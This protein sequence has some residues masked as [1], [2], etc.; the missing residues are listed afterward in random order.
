MNSEKQNVVQ[1]EIG[2]EKLE[3]LFN[4]GELCAADFRC[5][6]CVSKKCV[7]N[8]CLTSCA[9]RMRCNL[10]PFDNHDYCEQSVEKLLKDSS[11][12]ISVKQEHLV[13]LAS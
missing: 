5:L 3:S 10:M 8:L 13:K 12:Y 9:K 6:N 1:I 11:I 7:W 2:I 4:D